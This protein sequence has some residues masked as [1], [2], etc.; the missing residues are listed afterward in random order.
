MTRFLKFMQSAPWSARFGMFV[1]A[2]YVFVAF[3]VPVLAPFGETELVGSSYQGWDS[4]YWLGTDSLGR[5]MF[6]RILYGARNTIGIRIRY[7][8]SCFPFGWLARL[9]VSNTWWLG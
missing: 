4:T 7:N 1:I 3:F 8:L 9:H 5:D 6:T 2:V